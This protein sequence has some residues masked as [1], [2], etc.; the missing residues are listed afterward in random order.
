LPTPD[1]P[2]QPPPSSVLAEAG[3]VPPVPEPVTVARAGSSSSGAGAGAPDIEFLL[4][5]RRR[6]PAALGLFYDRYLDLVFGLAWRLTGDRTRAEDVTSEVFLKV[7]R[8]AERLDPA[9]DPAP[10]LTTITTNTCRDLWRSGAF[11]MSR[12][13]ADIDDPL[14]AASLST[15]RNDPEADTLAL[16]RERVVQRALLELPEPLR[17]AIVLH[18]YEGLDHREVAGVLR[19]AHDAAR[20]RY[21]R[22]LAALEQKLKGRL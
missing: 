13:A 12:R 3:S 1:F 8:A 20:K 4:R 7:H 9:R 21:S 15:G 10:W 5:V 19:I 11:R 22:A 2:S 18:D 17:T 6:E 14:Q 16:E